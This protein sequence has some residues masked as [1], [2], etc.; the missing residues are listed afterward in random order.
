MGWT[1]DRLPALVSKAASLRLVRIIED[2]DISLGGAGLE[3][4]LMNSPVSPYRVGEE[5]IIKLPFPM[6]KMSKS[7]VTSRFLISIMLYCFISIP[8]LQ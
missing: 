1:S 5:Y 2:P 6:K 3:V 4:M 7:N 8:I